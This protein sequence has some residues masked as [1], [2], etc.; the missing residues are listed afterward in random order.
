MASSSSS[1]SLPPP[2]PVA[3]AAAAA[4]EEEEEEGATRPYNNN[5]PTYHYYSTSDNEDEDDEDE[6]GFPQLSVEPGVPARVLMHEYAHGGGRA[7]DTPDGAMAARILVRALLSLECAIDG[8]VDEDAIVAFAARE[9]LDVNAERYY[10]LADEWTDPPRPLLLAFML[11]APCAIHHATGGVR[12]P[13]DAGRRRV[14]R[15]L[16]QRLGADP[17]LLDAEGETAL[18]CAL[19]G[20]RV[21]PRELV[22]LL[23]A[24]VA[25][26]HLET[27]VLE[28]HNAPGAR[29]LLRQCGVPRPADPDALLAA[30]LRLGRTRR[31]LP[32]CN[33]GLTLAPLV[34]LL[35]DD[36][37]A[38]A[39]HVSGRLR[40]TPLHRAVLLFATSSP[41]VDYDDVSELMADVD[42]DET[43]AVVELLLD[44]GADPWARD[45]H[46]VTPYD[47]WVEQR[48]RDPEGDVALL[49]RTAR[50]RAERRATAVAMALHARLGAASALGALG[51]DLLAAIV[52]DR[53]QRDAPPVYETRLRR[54]RR[55]LLTRRLEGGTRYHARAAWYFLFS[56][57]NGLRELRRAHF[58]RRSAEF[59][60]RTALVPSGRARAAIAAVLEETLPLRYFDDMAYGLLL[61]LRDAE[62]APMSAAAEDDAN[63]RAARLIHAR[64]CARLARVPALPSA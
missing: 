40:R 43:H 42:E 18:T 9:R 17:E 12:W 24:R 28:E 1:S 8:D 63:L 30:V 10:T 11:E 23:G 22:R 36:C 60:V 29:A 25:P 62:D 58:V 38:R 21:A 32:R 35:L 57:T 45:R 7:R 19:R 51:R 20:G 14:L 31:H 61:R 37:G 2:P 59:F 64:L 53:V 47:L 49:L 33:G 48:H 56:E 13:T 34:Q 41:T 3:V 15:L 46:G 55:R 44:A 27:L 50:R 6:D 52:V 5:N 16:G 54:L 26:D 4:S 39:D